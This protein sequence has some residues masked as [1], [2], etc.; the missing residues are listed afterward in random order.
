VNFGFLFNHF[1]ELTITG[2]TLG[3][4]YALV[5]LGYTMVYGVLQLINF[6]HSEVF[7][8]GTFAVAWVVVFFHGTSSTSQSLG[9]TLGLMSIALV[10]AMLTSAAIAMLLERVAYR[11]LINRGAPKLI[12]L[13]SAIG[14]SF[15]LAEIMGLRD[16]IAG[17]FGLESKLG[18]YVGQ[19]RNVYSSPVTIQPRGLFNIGGYEVTDVDVLILASALIMMFALDQFVRRSKVGRGIRAVAQ[20]PESAA[21]MGVN[22]T[23][24]IQVT[25]LL[26]GI[27]AGAAATLYMIRIGSTRQNAGFIFGVKAFTAAVMGG[28]GNLRGA[29][30]GGLVLGVVENWGSAVFGTEWK[31]VVAF[32]ML[33]L[34]LLVRPQGLLGEALGKARA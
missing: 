18:D 6:A 26:G 5:A 20:D 3:A 21:L 24:V 7:M 32:V 10:A 17:F 25:F 4:V 34:I 16:K 22:S 30:L 14:A 11:P 28:I 33:I 27:M 2:L 29:L 15:S 31:D 9:S 8:F 13:I 12:I 19:A 23:R 1:A